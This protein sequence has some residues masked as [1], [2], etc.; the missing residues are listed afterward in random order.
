MG[1]MLDLEEPDIRLRLYITGDTLIHDQLAEIPR[2]Y[3]DI[4]L[5]PSGRPTNGVAAQAGMMEP[6]IADPS[7]AWRGSAWGGIAGPGVFVAAWLVGGAIRRGYSPIDDAISQLAAVGTPGRSLM[8][9]GFVGFGV[10][11]PIYAMAL[12]RSVPGPAWGTAVATGLATLGVAAVPLGASSTTDTAH[13]GL[14]ALAYVALAATPLL[15]AGPLRA[16]GRR[17]AAAAS[18]ATGVTTALCLAATTL[19]PAHGLLQR[20]GLTLGDAWLAAS[21]AWMLRGGRTAQSVS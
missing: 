4:D 19:G 9:A 21:A 11:V 7:P 18:V 3:P 5:P 2:R 14:A 17:P 16:S 13:A 12:R 6:M 8:T 20:A 10:G 15:A 1:S